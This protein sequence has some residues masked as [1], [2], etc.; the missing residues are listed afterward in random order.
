MSSAINGASVARGTSFLKDKMNEL[1]FAKGVNIID[2]PHRLRGLRSASFD[3]EGLATTKRNIID[4]GRLTTWFLD[5][6]SAKQL[7]LKSTGHASRGVSSAP[8]PSSSNLYLAPGA[9]TLDDMI[10]DITQGFFVTELI[11]MGVS[12]ITGDYSR[13]ASGF[14]IENGELTYAVSEV[15]VAGNLLD[16]F[17]TLTPASDLEF[18]H[19]LDAPSVRIDGLTIAG[20]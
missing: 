19:G 8:S 14:W 9:Q 3:D 7:G 17:K 13:G 5:L 2:D 6:R 16:M 10:K 20:V 1:V 15:T 11:G 12:G 18:R 4:D